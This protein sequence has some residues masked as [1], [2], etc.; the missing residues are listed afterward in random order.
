MDNT[1]I[2]EAVATVLDGVNV[3]AKGTADQ[4]ATAIAEVEDLIVTADATV[5]D[6]IVT[7]EATM[8]GMAVEAEAEVVTRIQTGDYPTYA[9]P[10]EV[11]P[12]AAEAQVLETARKVVLQD[13][14]VHEIPYWETSN[15]SGMTAFIASEV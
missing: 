10:H 8:E 13:I 9:G 5:E 2:V 1:M 15:Q 6:L 3:T 7:A 14:T 11:T 4:P 12:K